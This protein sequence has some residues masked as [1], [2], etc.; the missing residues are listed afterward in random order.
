M[1]QGLL[2]L[3]CLCVCLSISNISHLGVSIYVTSAIRYL[4]TLG[5]HAQRGLRYSVCVSVCFTSG[6]SVSPK[7]LLR[8]QWAM[9]VKKN[10]G[11]FS[12][13]HAFQV[14]SSPSL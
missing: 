14:F 12:E 4:F 5:V 3:G 11:V 10:C 2:C 1:H 7:T 13:T 9:K 6:A 8:T